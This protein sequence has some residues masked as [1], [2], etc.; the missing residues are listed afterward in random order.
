[1]RNL[2]KS[3]EGKSTCKKKLQKVTKD[4]PVLSYWLTKNLNRLWKNS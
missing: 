4:L 3:E 2:R 1:L